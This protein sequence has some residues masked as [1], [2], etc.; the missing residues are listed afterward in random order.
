MYVH[1][2]SRANLQN[3]CVF[4]YTSTLQVKIDMCLC[5]HVHCTCV[6]MYA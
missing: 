1:M 3:T 4:M 2:S 5:I 6:F